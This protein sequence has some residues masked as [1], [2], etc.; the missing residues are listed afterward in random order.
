MRAAVQG[1]EDP[2]ALADAARASRQQLRGSAM[3]GFAQPPPTRQGTKALSQRLALMAEETAYS[4]PTGA[5]GSGGATGVATVPVAP[6][7]L[8]NPTN[9][10]GVTSTERLASQYAPLGSIGWRIRERREYLEDRTPARRF[11]QVPVQSRGS[12]GRAPCGPRVATSPYGK[13][14][15][16]MVGFHLGL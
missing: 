5:S 1:V 12:R 11:D 7:G 2:G 16:G 4:R 10:E 6:L 3:K 15:L 9:S 8:Q 13:A 14:L